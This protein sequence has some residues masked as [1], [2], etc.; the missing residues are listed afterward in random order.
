MIRYLGNLLICSLSFNLRVGLLMTVLFFM[1]GK[2]SAQNNNWQ[3]ITSNSSVSVYASYA[4][5][6][7]DA[8]LLRF[9]NET[10]DPVEIDFT[11]LLTKSAT[12]PR[13]SHTITL[14]PNESKTGQC[15]AGIPSLLAYPVSEL[16]NRDDPQQEIQLNMQVN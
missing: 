2:I 6:K 14:E 8:W 9:D 4:P 1:I 13:M 12:I 7:E 11:I 5:C 10:G 3:L 16:K 15:E